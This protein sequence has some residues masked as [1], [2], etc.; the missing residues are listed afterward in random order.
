MT[1]QT[2]T[3][4]M[5]DQG[6]NIYSCFGDTHWWLTGRYSILEK[7]IKQ[8]ADDEDSRFLDAG[9]GP[10]VFLKRLSRF[11]HG[12]I[13]GIDTS[14]YGLGLAKQNLPHAQFV[15][16]DI[17]ALPFP[18][19]YFDIILADDVIEHIVEDEKAI[20]EIYRT[21]K[22]GG[23]AFFCVPAFMSLWGYHDEKYGHK[24]R[25][26]IAQFRTKLASAGFNIETI[27]YGQALFFIPLFIFRLI[28]NITKSKREDFSQLPKALNSLL[29]LLVRI[30]FFLCR[31][32]RIPFGCNIF[33]VSSK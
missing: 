21:L 20:V 33:C 18:A 12:E 5:F 24:R 4:R 28:K 9:C 17:S 16:G 8:F 27:V 32:F 29:R 14:S 23:Y 13:Y 25:Y 31:S 7:Y 1:G 10:A 3:S 15:E 26:T 11:I 2:E 30:D 6:Q 19:N 22:K